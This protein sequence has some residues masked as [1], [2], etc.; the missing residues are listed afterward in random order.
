MQRPELAETNAVKNGR[1]YVLYMALPLGI[2]GPV[3]EVYA[4]KITQPDLFK[5]LD[6]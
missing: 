4:A 3:G 1:V 5:D 2:Q 6:Q